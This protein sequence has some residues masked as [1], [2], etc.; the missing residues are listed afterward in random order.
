MIEH[1]A[2]VDEEDVMQVML[3]AAVRFMDAWEP[4]RGTPLKTFV[5]WRAYDKAE[6]FLHAQRGC[7]SGGNRTGPSRHDIPSA[8]IGIWLGPPLFSGSVMEP[9]AFAE[10]ASLLGEAGC[11]R[12]VVE[13]FARMGSFESAAELVMRDP[14]LISRKVPPKNKTQALR[15]VRE[16][17][18]DL[19]ETSK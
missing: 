10:A 3:I 13:E 1:P 17:L 7:Q 16:R 12:P 8:G 2:H 5:V 11:F 4:E 15:I 19:V 9:T 6:K 14:S 18:R